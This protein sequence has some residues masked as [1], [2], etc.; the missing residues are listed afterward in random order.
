[1]NSHFFSPWRLSYSAALFSFTAAGYN[2]INLSCCLIL[3]LTYDLAFL[4][5][6]L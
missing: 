2:V 4:T 1:M 3:Q 6:V 5:L